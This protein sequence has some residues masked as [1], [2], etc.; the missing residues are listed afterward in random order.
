LPRGA[1][2]EALDFSGAR[3]DRLWL[4]RAEIVACRFDR[5]RC[6][7][8]RLTACDIADTSF[9]GADLRDATLGPWYEGRSTVYRRVDF[10]GADLRGIGSTSA[11]YIDCDFSR[12][13]LRKVDFFSSSFIR[14]RFAGELRE[15]EFWDRSLSDKP[16]PNPMEDIDFSAAILR[17][18]RFGGLNLDRVTFP[19]DENHVIVRHY[20]CVLPR[21]V[22]LIGRDGRADVLGNVLGVRLEMDGESAGP[23]QDVGVFSRLDMLEHNAEEDV[24]YAMAWLRRVEDAC[25]ESASAG[26]RPGSDDTSG[27]GR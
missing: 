11:T 26:D 2:L 20:R 16:D 9:A 22:R 4:V 23:F 27:A 25:A 5:A 8:C 17:S 14:C 10:S 6:R 19:E 3:L 13:N 7:D 12:A 18:V 1:R 15:V 21:A 24:A